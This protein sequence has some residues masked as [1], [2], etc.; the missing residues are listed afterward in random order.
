M[1]EFQF[2]YVLCSAA[3]YVAREQQFVAVV[4]AGHLF[5]IEEQTDG[6]R[7]I[8]PTMARGTLW[9]YFYLNGLLCYMRHKKRI[10]K[11]RGQEKKIWILCDAI[12]ITSIPICGRWLEP[13]SCEKDKQI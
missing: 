7:R 6:G 1:S 5:R 2:C 11:K 4:V 13:L 9:I 3:S 8:D 12:S 10:D